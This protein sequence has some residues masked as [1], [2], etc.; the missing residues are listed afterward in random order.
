MKLNN[1]LNKA[2]KSQDKFEKVMND[3]IRIV[4]LL[5]T[6]VVILENKNYD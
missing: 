2:L 1:T 6:R 5:N 3:L 4:Q